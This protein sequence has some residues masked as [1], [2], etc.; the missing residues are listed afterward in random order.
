MEIIVSFYQGNPD[1]INYQIR[2]NNPQCY[3]LEI[4][5]DQNIWF[6]LKRYQQIYQLKVYLESKYKIKVPQFPKKRIFRNYVEFTI[7]NRI[8]K[9]NYFFKFINQPHIVRDAYYQEFLKTDICLDSY[10]DIQQSDLLK[11]GLI[12]CEKLD[13]NMTNLTDKVTYIWEETNSLLN[14]IT[15]IKLDLE[16]HQEKNKTLMDN[17]TGLETDSKNCHQVKVEIINE[18][19]DL[20][21][22]YQ[23]LRLKYCLIRS[24]KA[25]NQEEIN[26]SKHQVN[27]LKLQLNR[28]NNWINDLDDRYINQYWNIVEYQRIH[29]LLK[30]KLIPTVNLLVTQQLS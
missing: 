24:T 18:L 25:C 8:T 22:Q 6:I 14:R 29:D 1:L 13:I 28:I 27:E 20:D 5:E 3:L 19:D 17:L 10:R 7:N 11:K 26:Q 15:E 21:K 2:K 30:T 12:D 16:K 23:A 4:M 9:F